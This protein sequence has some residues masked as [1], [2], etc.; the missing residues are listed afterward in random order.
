MDPSDLLSLQSYP[1][2]CRTLSQRGFVPLEEHQTQPFKIES[3]LI[4]NEKI[5]F[6]SDIILSFHPDSSLKTS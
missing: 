4:Q 6:I 3:K 1:M 2:P 5:I